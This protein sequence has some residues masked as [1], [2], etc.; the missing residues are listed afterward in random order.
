MEKNI[1]NSVKFNKIV[2]ECRV[3]E[4]QELWSDNVA[5]LFMSVLMDKTVDCIRSKLEADPTLPARTNMSNQCSLLDLYIRCAY[6]VFNG[7]YYSQIHG[8]AMGSAVSMIVC[9]AC[10]EDIEEKA[11]TT[12]P[13][14]PHWW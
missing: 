10:V 7:Q 14:I 9:D 3:E 2:Q 6:F 8:A 5:A 4:D 12:A 1:K 11:Y 13:H